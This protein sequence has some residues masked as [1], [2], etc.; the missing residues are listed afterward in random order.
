[1]SAA[2][3]LQSSLTGWGALDLDNPA[4]GAIRSEQQEQIK[5]INGDMRELFLD[6]ELGLRVLKTLMDWTIKRPTVNPMGN[7]RMDVWRGGQ[8]D[9]VRCILKAIHNSEIGDNENG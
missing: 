1:M 7:E 4:F 3:D 8:D 5:Q 6:S 2:N 9:I